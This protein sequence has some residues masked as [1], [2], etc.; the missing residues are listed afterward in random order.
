[1]MTDSEKIQ[2]E[3]LDII[4]ETIQHDSLNEINYLVHCLTERAV[5]K[6]I[7]MSILEKIHARADI[8]PWIQRRIK[9]GIELPQIAVGEKTN[10]DKEEIWIYK[11]GYFERRLLHREKSRKFLNYIYLLGNWLV[12]EPYLPKKYLRSV[13]RLI[14]LLF[15][16]E[17]DMVR[18]EIIRII[19]K[20]LRKPPY[21][22]D[23]RILNLLSSKLMVG[24]L[25][26]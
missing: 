26:N 6:N 24:G 5:D 22:I 17:S 7:L 16:K 1:M 21:N 13:I 20:I 15:R 19:G 11:L 10:N 12:S 8:D 9:Q 23:Q 18:K 14:L 25:L 2:K 3:A 4:D